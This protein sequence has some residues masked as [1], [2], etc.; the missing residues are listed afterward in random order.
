MKLFL[1]IPFL[2]LLA[3][4]IPLSSGA[5][6]NLDS[7][8]GK[9]GQLTTEFSSFDDNAHAITVQA[10]G[11]I[12]VAGQSENG[13]DTDFAIV[14]Y[15]GDGSLD[16]DFNYTGQVTI[17]VGSGNDHALA[18]I[19]Q[20]DG[21]ILVAGTT[22][23]DDGLDVAV[24]RLQD[25]GL[26]DMDFDSDGQ[27]VIPLPD[28]DDKAQSILLQEDGKIILAGTS[29]TNEQSQ[30]FLARLNS[31]GSLDTDFG[32]QGLANVAD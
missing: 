30:I 12:L 3:M 25:D 11:K 32:E 6:E 16:K 24:I 29:E 14:R 4:S 23:N 31:D 9:N 10:D 5:Q 22:D 15:H 19:V 13:A 8:F 27:V 17:A 18:I 7:S 1:Q 26:P 2:L 20:E 21:K 28:S